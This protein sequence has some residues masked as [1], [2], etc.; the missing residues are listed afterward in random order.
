MYGDFIRQKYNEG[1]N[2][3]N[4]HLLILRD[5]KSSNLFA[6]YLN[7]EYHNLLKK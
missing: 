3:D 1:K 4:T 5:K 7:K 2:T 6:L